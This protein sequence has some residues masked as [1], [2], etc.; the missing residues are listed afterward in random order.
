[1]IVGQLYHLRKGISRVYWLHL[2]S[3]TLIM[4]I[5]HMAGVPK[6]CFHVVLYMFR[7]YQYLYVHFYVTYRIKVKFFTLISFVFHLIDSSDYQ[8]GVVIK[9][10]DFCGAT[11]QMFTF[12]KGIKLRAILYHALHKNVVHVKNQQRKDDFSVGCYWKIGMYSWLWFNYCY[13]LL[14]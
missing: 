12:S 2:I 1:M 6:Y 8:N 14:Q 3:I 4:I 5:P 13:I 10:L 7:I 11:L 9:K